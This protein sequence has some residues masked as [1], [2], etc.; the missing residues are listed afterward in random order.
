MKKFF[1]V[2]GLA[3][4]VLFA[5]LFVVMFP[6]INAMS[7][8]GVVD[9]DSGLK[10]FTGGGG[11][12]VVYSAPDKS[13]VIVIDTKM[14]GSARKL[15]AYVDSINPDAKVTVINTHAHPD[16]TGGNK[17]FTKAEFI[18]GGYENAK[19][20]VL[21]GMLIKAGETYTIKVPDDELEIRNMGNAHSFA[22]VIVYFKKRKLLVT[23]D[24][25]FNGWHPAL[26]KQGG[27]D[28]D[29]WVKALDYLQKNFDI[30]T[31]V[32]G[33]GQVSDAKILQE[34]K[35]YFED[36]KAAVNNPALLKAL[37]EKY[38]GYMHI[39]V[40]SGFDNTVKFLK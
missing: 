18:T 3:I 30:K 10:I 39:P 14:G 21:Q 9:F 11:N 12:S 33:H 13:T 15:K 26:I 28:T 19:P 22:D 35:S 7:K 31:A 37:N 24:L 34:Q 1:A 32:P 8:F 2:I 29:K 25:V 23:G 6:A 27:A 36:I 16:H 4:L 5:G 40:M 17:L 20:G 38:K